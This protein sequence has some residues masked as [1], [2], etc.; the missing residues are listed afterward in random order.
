V[1]DRPTRLAYYRLALIGLPALAACS[2]GLASIA[3][4]DLAPIGPELVAEWRGGFVPDRHRRYDIRWRFY[5]P[6]GSTAGRAAIRVAPPDSLRFDYRGPFG[7]SGAALVLGDSVA[8]AEPEKDVRDLIRLAPV[9]WAALGIPPAPRAGATT[10]ARDG[11]SRRAW[12]QVEGPDT[13]DVVHVRG[14]GPRLLSQ[15]RQ[16]GI[17]A[18]TDTRFGPDG[19]PVRGEMRFPRDGSAFIFTVETA[20]TAVTFDAATW[21]H[22]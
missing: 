20:D 15:L 13:L 19:L 6:K 1:L 10:S 14:A 9:F 22:P 7:R 17:T 8:W 12:R 11:A 5:T 2:A 18:A 4:A 21:R 16:G 3:P